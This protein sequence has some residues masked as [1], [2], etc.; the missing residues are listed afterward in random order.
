M[1]LLKKWWF[2]LIVLITI[3]ILIFIFN[4]PNEE[5]SIKNQILNKTKNINIINDLT[6]EKSELRWR[7]YKTCSGAYFCPEYNKT[8]LPNMVSGDSCYN[9]GEFCYTGHCDDTL[10]C[11]KEDQPIC[12]AP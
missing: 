9:E 6:Q 1:R 7:V 11:S 12:L 8:C 2:W 5:A 3:L 10:K 4:L